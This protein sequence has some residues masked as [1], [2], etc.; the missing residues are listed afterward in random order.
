MPELAVS[1]GSA[2]NSDSDEPSYVL[3][4]LGRSPELAQSSLR[5][6]LGRFSSERDVDVA[7]AVIARELRRL[8]RV[9]P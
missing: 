7:I 9:A 4:A 6:S 1:T 2:C 3:I 5:L 8:R